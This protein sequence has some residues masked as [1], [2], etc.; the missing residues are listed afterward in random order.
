MNCR[1]IGFALGSSKTF[2]AIETEAGEER[3]HTGRRHSGGKPSRAR[4]RAGGSGAAVDSDDSTYQSHKFIYSLWHPNSSRRARCSGRFEN[5]LQRVSGTG[6]RRLDCAGPY[7]AFR[8]KIHQYGKCCGN[9]AQGGRPCQG[10][11]G[12]RYAYPGSGLVDALAGLTL[13]DW[14]RR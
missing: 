1:S 2:G 13:F 14:T 6:D 7:D 4:I 9:T 3:A 11:S 10:V 8:N 5:A 12:A